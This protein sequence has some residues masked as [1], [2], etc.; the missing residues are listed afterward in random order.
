MLAVQAVLPAELPPGET[1]RIGTDL[2]KKKKK[3]LSLSPIQTVGRYNERKDPQ[4]RLQQ[5][6]EILKNPSKKK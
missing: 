6:H 3:N 4:C 5:K 1:A 2:L